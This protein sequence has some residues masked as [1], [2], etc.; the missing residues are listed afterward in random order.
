M[1]TLT[2]GRAAGLGR[3][4]LTK[5]VGYDTSSQTG[6]F[7]SSDR[8]NSDLIKTTETVG[9]R[10][11]AL[12]SLAP[13]RRSKASLLASQ[14]EAVHTTP[15]RPRLKRSGRI[16]LRWSAPVSFASPVSAG[17]NCAPYAP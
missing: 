8:M 16:I 10:F 3:F 9:F 13:K 17:I 5:K 2:L 1:K 11:P 7:D 4:V 6:L 12:V 14:E 15:K